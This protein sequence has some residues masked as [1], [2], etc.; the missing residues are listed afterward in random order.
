MS[1]KQ[2]QTTTNKPLIV[3]SLEPQ[4]QDAVF[5]LF[6]GMTYQKIAKECNVKYGTVRLWFMTGGLCEP[7]YKELLALRARENRR[8]FKSLNKKFEEYA[9][10]ALET[11][12]NSTKAGNWKAAESLLD[13]AGFSPVNKIKAEVENTDDKE[14]SELVQEL[15]GYVKS[16]NLQSDKKTA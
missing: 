2:R 11:L 16:D 4:Y 15:R 13:R 1:N 14:V 10:D 12:H 9:P 7:A 6:G 3:E 8:K 5:M